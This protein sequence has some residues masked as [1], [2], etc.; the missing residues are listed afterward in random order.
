MNDGVDELSNSKPG[1]YVAKSLTEFK[2]KLTK[3]F[4]LKCEKEEN[5]CRIQ[6]F[7]GWKKKKGCYNDK[8]LLSNVSN[9]TNP[10]VVH[11]I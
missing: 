4:L 1:L 7:K 8:G 9:E 10:R 3:I 5:T 2:P 6:Q 11:K